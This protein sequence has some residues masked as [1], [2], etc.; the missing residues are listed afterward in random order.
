[1]GYLAIPPD[2]IDHISG[3]H[4]AR[5]LAEEQRLYELMSSR[6][7]RFLTETSRQLGQTREWRVL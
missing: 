4:D 7:H 5:V 3:H 6:S 1:M 2:V